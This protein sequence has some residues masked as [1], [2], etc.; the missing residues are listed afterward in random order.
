MKITWLGQAGL[1]FER[2]GLTLMVDPYLSDSVA[3]VN[4]ANYRRVPVDERF[5]DITPDVLLITHDHLDHYDPETAPRFFAKTDKRITVLAPT[6]AWNKARA[7][8]GVHYYV[9]MTRH[10]E[11]TAN[12]MRITAVK[13]AHSDPYALGYVLEDLVEDRTY[14]ITGDTLY[15]SEIFADLP[16][17]LDVVFCPINGVGNNMNAA[18][19]ARFCRNT[20]AKIAVPLHFGMFDELDPAS[21]FLFENRVIPVL[22]REIDLKGEKQ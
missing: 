17:H 22:Y 6:T 3:K 14:Y 16:K 7:H 21:L 9:E 20:G 1:L 2:E 15:N 5:F 12:G 8:G 10:C 13:A 18:D 11:W 4:P 19:A